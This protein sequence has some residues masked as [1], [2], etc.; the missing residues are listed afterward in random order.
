MSP[1]SAEIVRW[2]QENKRDLP[3][4]HTR[5]PYVIWLSE[6][7]LQQ[8]RVDQGR[9]YFERFLEQYPTVQAFSQASEDEILRLWQGLGYYSRAR[10]MHRAAKQVMEH[11]QGQFPTAY[12]ELLQLKGI[13]E[14]T[15]SAIS[16]FAADE[17]RAVLDGNVFRVLSR[18]FGVDTPINSGAGKKVFQALAQEVLS[19]NQPGLHNQAMME[20]GALHCTPKK[21]DCL[22]CPLRLGC[23]AW[24]NGTVGE[25]PV[26]LKAKPARRRIFHYLLIRDGDRILM[27]KRGAGDI[28]QNL[29]EFP[30]IEEIS[31]IEE[32]PSV[33]MDPTSSA[34]QPGS[35]KFFAELAQY[36][37]PHAEIS[38]L[39]GPIKHVLSHQHLFAY[40]WS[41][42]VLPSEI[43][44]K[45]GW[46]Y[47]DTK[48]LNTLAKPKLIVSFLERAIIN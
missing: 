45:A 5:D 27:N 3:W 7:I 13:G 28:W 9:P 36:V 1:F 30:L 42:R 46:D 38:L 4:R 8:T 20:F 34:A 44:K 35:E 37:G 11:Y 14:Y 2:Y 47:V 40:F 29:Y 33:S 31:L 16:S 25:L 6:I 22:N 23:V 32:S 17:A 21:P 39:E 48:E 24:E 12:H 15:A 10:N 18:Y 19:E 41:V 43:K 26:K